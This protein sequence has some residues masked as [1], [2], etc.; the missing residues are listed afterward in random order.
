MR[1]LTGGAVGDWI[2]VA[3]VGMANVVHSHQIVYRVTATQVVSSETGAPAENPRRHYR[4]T[5]DSVGR[6]A[7][8]YGY[9]IATTRCQRRKG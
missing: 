5:G 3:G 9:T 4:Q 2:C 1:D 7:N 6:A 8:P